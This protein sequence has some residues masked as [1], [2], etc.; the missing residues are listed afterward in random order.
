MTQG[1]GQSPETVLVSEGHAAPRA[2]LIQVACGATE[3]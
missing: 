1:S 3:P 2:I